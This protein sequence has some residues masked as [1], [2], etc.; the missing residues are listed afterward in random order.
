MPTRQP[1]IWLVVLLAAG[2]SACSTPKV[3]IRDYPEIPISAPSESGY[4]LDEVRTAIVRAGLEKGW[5]METVSRTQISGTLHVRSHTAMVDI[6]YDTDGYSI[7]YRDS[8][9]LERD[10]R[11]IHPNYNLWVK[12][13]ARAINERLD[14]SVEL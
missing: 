8:R 5:E 11:Y 13:L 7:K 10:G 3:H 9:N 14:T 2:L 4:T 6:R 1:G 12:H